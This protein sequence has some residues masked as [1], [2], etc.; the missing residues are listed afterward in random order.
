MMD[1]LVCGYLLRQIY[2][3]WERIA[4]ELLKNSDLNWTQVAVLG[5]LVNCENQEMSLKELEKSL[6]LTQSVVAR[7]VTQMACAGYLEY[8]LN[9]NDKRVK[10]VHLLAKG[11]DCHK[12][13]FSGMDVTEAPLLKGMSTGESLIFKELLERALEN[14][15]LMQEKLKEQ[16]RCKKEDK[17]KT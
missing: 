8:T 1:G 17:N 3:V 12:N 16:N 5:L 4:K 9:P 13:I 11:M 14:S 10:K 15:V 7:S 2:F 6:S